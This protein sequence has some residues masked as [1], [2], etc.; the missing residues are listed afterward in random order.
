MRSDVASKAVIGPKRTSPILWTDK[1]DT[2]L[3]PV[4]QEPAR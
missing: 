2:L 4:D 3:S 1:A